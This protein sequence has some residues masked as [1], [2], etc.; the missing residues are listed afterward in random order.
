MRFGVN[1]WFWVW[2]FTTEN[3]DLVEKVAGLGFDWIEIPIE[4]IEQ[5]ID[6]R[7]VRAA[8]QDNDLGVSVCALF[9]DDCDFV[10]ED[11]AKNKAGI[12]YVKHCIDAA[13]SMGGSRIGGPLFSSIGR[14]WRND[15]R[16]R[17]LDRAAC[18]LR[19]VGGYAEDRGVVI[20]LEPL[21]RFETSFINTAEQALELVERTDSPAIQCM[22]DT[23]HMNIEEKDVAQAI[24]R[25][26]KHLV[27][28]HSNENDR[29]VP[30]SGH[31]DWAGVTQVL[32]KIN[33]D[34]A[35][36]IESFDVRMRGLAEAAWVWRPLVANEE[37]LTEGLRF[38]RGLFK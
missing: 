20:G 11:A 10:I 3:L 6:C 5:P 12:A 38:L 28:I 8:I 30:G 19:E 23:Y 26:G 24:G 37:S 16:E 14:R 27:H 32:K 7:E 36:V 25:M 2:H 35:L 17:D 9:D 4:S 15:S 31:V 22:A 1:T 29:G 13:A 34:G 33:Y 18:R 21:N